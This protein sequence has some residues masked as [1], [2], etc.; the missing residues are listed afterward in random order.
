MMP[1]NVMAMNSVPTRKVSQATALSQVS[2]QLAAAVGTAV[3]AAVLTVLRPEGNLRAPGTVAA[4]VDAYD[5]IFMIVAVMLVIAML[6]AFRLPGKVGALALQAERKRERG[7]L[8]ELGEL[9]LET[10]SGLA[11]EVL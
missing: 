6:L 11:A 8:R 9:D 10:E 3:L 7:F 4:T 2:R 1:P 5:T